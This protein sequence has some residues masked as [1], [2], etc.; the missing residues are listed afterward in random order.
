MW[1]DGLGRRGLCAVATGCVGMP[2]FKPF[3]GFGAGGVVRR[4]G[5][6]LGSAHTLNCVVWVVLDMGARRASMRRWGL[7]FAQGLS[8]W[9]ALG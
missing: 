2:C 6:R 7:R 3:R 5:R 1:A 9:S 4:L 8:I